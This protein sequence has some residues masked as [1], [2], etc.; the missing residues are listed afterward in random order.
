MILLDGDLLRA[1]LSR[2]LGFST[3]DRMENIR[4]AGE[5]AKLLSDA[6]HTVLA[7]FITPLES[8]RQAV[9]GIFAPGRYVEIFLDCPLPVCEARDPK[10][11][12]SRARSGEIPEFTGISSPFEQPAGSD[13]TVRTGDQTVEESVNSIL[14][15]LEQRFVD[16]RHSNTTGRSVRTSTGRVVVLGLDCV[17][18][19]LVFDEAGEELHNLRALVSHGVWGPLRSTDPPITVPAWTTITTGKDPGELGIYGF[20]NRMDHG[21]DEMVVVN[22]GHV[23]ARRVWN[24]L[25]DVGKYSIL[26]GVPQT[27]PPQAHNG[28]TVADF[29]SPEVDP[30]PTHPAELAE[31]LHRLAGGPYI[32][33]VKDFRNKDRKELLGDLYRMTKYRFRLASDLLLRKPWDFFMMVEIATDRLHHAFWRFAAR[34]HRLYEPGNPFENVIGQFYRYLDSCIGSLLALLDDDTTVLVISDHGAKS[35]VGGV[36]INQW[37][38]DHGYLVLKGR[39]DAGAPLSPDMID[40]PRTKVWSEGG[41]YARIF[42]NVKGRERQGAVEPGDYDALR[43][44]LARQL[45]S[46][47]DE[48]GRPMSNQILKPEDIY[49]ACANVPPDLLVYFD[50]LAR[51]A[52]GNVGYHE[53]LCSENNTGPDDA[54]HDPTGIFIGTRM[55]DLRRGVVKGTRIPDASC[56]D[57]T[58][59]ILHE[60]GLPKPADLGGKVIDLDTEARRDVVEGDTCAN[61][62]RTHVSSDPPETDHGYTSE[63][64]EIVKKRLTELGYF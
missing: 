36:R 21:Y 17:P 40:W 19:Q 52:V 7:A 23:H 59:T 38:I 55:R 16:L 3:L 49:R 5:T 28:I 37:L 18:P 15:F 10:G 60:F 35:M 45:E 41:Y 54:N 51:R 31:E 39:P 61:D 64:A 9:R 56:L 4:R 29:L 20:R 34:D 1:G 24:H 26:V 53:V 57:I 63:E 33:D 32:A 58:P 8:I 27:Y 48:N 2:D 44:E 14:D 6:G 46:M 47:P 22:A 62:N 42:F 43:K 25:E 13:F 30:P 12:Y 11:L 50:S